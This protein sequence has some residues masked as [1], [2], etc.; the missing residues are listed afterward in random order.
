[1]LI[2]WLDTL[3]RIRTRDFQDA[4]PATRERAA[5]D[6]VNIAS[7]ACAAVAVSPLPLSDA[8]LMLPIQTAMV[9]TVGHIY[10]RRL[11]QAE[12]KDLIAEL[13]T[14]AG[15]SFLI[16]QGVKALLPVVGALITI[17]AA[18]A[19]NWGIG[20]VAMEY[21]KNPGL[22]REALRKVYAKAKEEGGGQFSK[23]AFDELRR[24]HE[25]GIHE[26]AKE[27]PASPPPATAAPAPSPARKKGKTIGRGGPKAKSP[28]KGKSKAV[29]KSIGRRQA[30]AP[31]P[32]PASSPLADLIERELPRR[33]EARK[34]VA[35][36]MKAVVHLDLS[37]PDGGQW[38]MDL[39]RP[40]DPITRGLQGT[41]KL[42]VRAEDQL[43]L[44]LVQGKVDPQMAVLTGKLGLEP[45][46]LELAAG[47]ARLFTA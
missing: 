46:D 44:R 8:L 16:R 24:K 25:T 38:T 6:V 29:K 43:F 1:M 2:S 40:G 39:T 11:D 32:E 12:A 10:G 21:F 42:T 22:T 13:V 7:Y 41:P 4:S 9:M 19:A 35:A 27:A 47:I 15:A 31:E 33:L 45:L 20:R 23:S 26:V 5:R 17:P 28:P 3:E 36:Q 18:F 34:D 37:G 14:L 30:A